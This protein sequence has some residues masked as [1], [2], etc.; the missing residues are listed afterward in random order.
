MVVISASMKSEG[1]LGLRCADQK[2]RTKVQRGSVARMW[3]TKQP[4]M[5]QS[6]SN[7]DRARKVQKGNFS[8][9][10]SPSLVLPSNYLDD[11]QKILR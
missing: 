9:I 5:I 3:R 7:K 6:I 8:S 11:F 10:A 1:K 2:K 4:R